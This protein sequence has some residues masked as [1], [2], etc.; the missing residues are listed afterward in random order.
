LRGE[1]AW[2]ERADG[3]RADLR[4]AAPGAVADMAGMASWRFL[5]PEHRPAVAGNM[6]LTAGAWDCRCSAH[7]YR[8]AAAGHVHFLL[9][10]RLYPWDHAPGVLIH[11]EA[12][13]YSA[14]FD[15]S[16]YSPLEVSG[17]LICAPDENSWH[18]LRTALVGDRL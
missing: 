15:G 13:G 18:A 4:V 17:G 11:R 2:T 5:P 8:L 3:G 14:R 12:G 1:G 7:Q 10:Y 6:A 9:Y 16:P